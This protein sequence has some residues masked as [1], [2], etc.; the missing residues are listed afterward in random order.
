MPPS[1]VFLCLTADVVSSRT[2]P[3]S[4]QRLRQAAERVNARRARGLAVPFSVTVGDEIQALFTD[5]EAALEADLDLRLF[6]FPLRLRCGLGV[7]PVEGPLEAR[8]A[9]MEGECFLRSRE[10]LAEAKR[11]DSPLTWISSGAP[12][13]DDAANACFLAL[14]A[15]E[16]RWTEKQAQ[17]LEAVREVGTQAQAAR[18]LG[19]TQPSLHLR[20]KAAHAGPYLEARRRL[21]R[22]LIALHFSDTGRGGG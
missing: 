4:A 1:P 22:F 3:G 8:T 6:L 12:P 2:H 11:H 20:L 18:R 17:A 10:A 9:G 16:A 7:G 15:V 13:L 5:A 19:I 14:A 21:A